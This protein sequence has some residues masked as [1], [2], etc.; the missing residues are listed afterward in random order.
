MGRVLTRRRPNHHEQPAC[1][2]LS[3]RYMRNGQIVQSSLNANDVN[4]AGCPLGAT[5]ETKVLENQAV[6]VLGSVSDMKTEQEDDLMNPDFDAP[7]K[8]SS[9]GG[10]CPKWGADMV[11]APLYFR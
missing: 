8:G 2:A 3:V 7:G 6:L 5:V 10:S 11:R 9:L 4:C 1:I